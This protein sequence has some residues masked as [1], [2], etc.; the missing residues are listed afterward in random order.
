VGQCPD[1]DVEWMGLTAGED[2]KAVIDLSKI[3]QCVDGTMCSLQH[4]ARVLLGRKAPRMHHDPHWD[5][6]VSVE[7]YFLAAGASPDE[8]ASLRR[9][10]CGWSIDGVCLSMYSPGNCTCGMPVVQSWSF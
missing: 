4:E 7:L 8:L 10:R 1:G 5:A 3:F 6:L 2:F 9:R